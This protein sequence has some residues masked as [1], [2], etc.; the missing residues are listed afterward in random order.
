MKDNV[1]TVLIIGGLPCSGKSLLAAEF[2]RTLRWPLL[3]KDEIKE[4]LFSKLGWRDRE[5]SRRLSET[6]YALMFAHARELL[7]ARMNFILEGNF[8]VESLTADIGRL[9]AET[10]PRCVQIVCK[11]ESA[12]LV[13]RFTARAKAGTRHPGHVDLSSLA[14]ISAELTAAEAL[15][16][17]LDGPVFEWD[18]T[19]IEEGVHAELM[20]RVLTVLK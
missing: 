13:E 7:A 16:F 11:A 2:K 3:A 10:S 12:V 1:S 15:P 4:V 14:E 20:A 6:S 8:R 17:A 5:W 9:F 18:T 19:K